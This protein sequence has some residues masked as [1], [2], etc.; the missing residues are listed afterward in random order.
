MSMST[1]WSE[2]ECDVS[3]GM[4]ELWLVALLLLAFSAL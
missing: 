1:D 2:G 4:G 3:D